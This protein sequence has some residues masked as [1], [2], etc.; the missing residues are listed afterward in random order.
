MRQ[1]SP[2]TGFSPSG[3]SLVKELEA[4]GLGPETRSLIEFM[5]N[6]EVGHATLLTNMLGPHGNLDETGIPRHRILP[7][8]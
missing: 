4:A 3:D 8:G 6:Q 7:I 2:D 5:A 1:E